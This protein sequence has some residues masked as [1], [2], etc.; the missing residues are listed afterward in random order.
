MALPLY[1]ADIMYGAKIGQ[2]WLVW[3][4][5]FILKFIRTLH[6]TD[7]YLA[8]NNQVGLFLI[9]V[10]FLKMFVNYPTIVF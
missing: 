9:E 5:I 3:Y 6:K 2:V 4:L 1:I 7:S 8:K 10:L